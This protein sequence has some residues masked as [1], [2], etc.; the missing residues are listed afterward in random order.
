L[1]SFFAARAR[2]LQA[3]SHAMF[4]TVLMVA[5]GLAFALAQN[6]WLLILPR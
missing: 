6:I 4:S 3:P 2:P 1:T 5:G